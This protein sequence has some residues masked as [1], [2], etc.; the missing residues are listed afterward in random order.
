MVFYNI[1]KVKHIDNSIL[2]LLYHIY[3]AIRNVIFKTIF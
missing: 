3:L 1:L 2:G